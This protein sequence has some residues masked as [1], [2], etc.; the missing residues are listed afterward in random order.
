[1]ADAS[2][3][4]LAQTIGDCAYQGFALTAPLEAPRL[5]GL[6]HRLLVGEKGLDGDVYLVRE[7]S[8]RTLRPLA[9]IDGMTACAY[10]CEGGGASVQD[11]PDPRAAGKAP[12]VKVI[13]DIGQ[14]SS[15]QVL[16]HRGGGKYQRYSVWERA[17]ANRLYPHAQ[18]RT[19]PQC[20]CGGYLGTPRYFDSFPEMTA[21][22]V[23]SYTQ[24]GQSGKS[25]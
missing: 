9:L 22:Y 2:A 12:L 7:E 5:P 17:Q 16:I 13:G 4:P 1:M 15:G 18:L 14:A 6:T 8:D 10:G 23:L 19:I 20:G 21:F 25:A 11:W 3:C 24:S